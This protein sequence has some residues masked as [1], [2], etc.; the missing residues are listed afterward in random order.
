MTQFRLK[1]CAK[2][3]GDLALDE[4][5]WICLQCGTYYYVGLYHHK[6]SQPH[7]WPKLSLPQEKSALADDM[8]AIS[9]PGT[10]L[11]NLLAVPWVGKRVSEKGRWR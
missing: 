8:K 2:C 1:A 4:G 7:Q 11:A 9:C 6:E 3:G 5:D 10:V